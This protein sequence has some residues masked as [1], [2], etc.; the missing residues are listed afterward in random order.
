[1][2]RERQKKLFVELINKQ[3]EPF[4]KTYEDVVNVPNWYM[5]YQTS[6]EEQKKFTDYCANRISKEL[7]LTKKMAEM[8]ASWFI[9]Q[10]GLTTSATE[11]NQQTERDSIPV[12]IKKKN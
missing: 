3:L 7:G 11:Y 4:G 1:M 9:L 12:E 8:E 6:P 2:S 5:N 10:W